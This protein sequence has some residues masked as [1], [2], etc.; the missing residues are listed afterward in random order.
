MTSPFGAGSGTC[1][2]CGQPGHWHDDPACPLRA[3]AV[4]KAAHEA[5]IDEFARRYSEFE[6]TEWQ[7]REFIREENKL[8]YDGKVPSRIAQ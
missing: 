5:R 7:K 6:I 1:H 8:W 2:R 3:K 4:S